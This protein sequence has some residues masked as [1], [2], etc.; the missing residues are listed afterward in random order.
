MAPRTAGQ[1]GSEGCTT[2]RAPPLSYPDMGRFHKHPGLVQIPRGSLIFLFLNLSHHLWT[3]STGRLARSPAT[4]SGSLR[5]VL[6]PPHVTRHSRGSRDPGPV[7]WSQSP[8]WE[9]RPLLLGSQVLPGSA[10]PGHALPALTAPHSLGTPRGSPPPSSHK[11]PAYPSM[12]GRELAWGFLPI[13]LL[14]GHR[15]PHHHN[16][17]RLR[18]GG[19]RPAGDLQEFCQEKRRQGGEQG[20]TWLARHVISFSRRQH[21]LDL[22]HAAASRIK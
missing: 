14:L 18:A 1:G 17:A 13:A 20:H 15:H 7:A 2:G 21:I 19:R 6:F 16:P 9:T 3:H 8:S 10:V 4:P 12:E 5:W 11:H 22:A